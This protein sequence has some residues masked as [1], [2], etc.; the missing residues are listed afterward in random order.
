MADDRGGPKRLPRGRLGRLARLAAIGARAGSSRI[1]G[2]VGSRD[3]A[4]RKVAEAAAEALGNLRGLALKAGQMASYV[5]GTVP[6]EHRDLYEEAMK[7]LR[8]AAPHMGADGA[9]R[10]IERELGAAPEDL[11]A[12]WEPEPFASASIGQVHRATLDDGSAVAVKVQLEG[13]EQA[14]RADLDNAT[15]MTSLLGPLGT[16]FGIGEQMEE[17]RSR[18]LEELDYVHEATRQTR[19]A[20]LFEGDATVRVPAI[21]AERST[22]RVLTAELAT[23]RSFDAARAAPP[24]ERQ[25]WARTLWRFVFHSLFTEGLFNADP[26]PGNYIFDA[27]GVVH[28]LD[29]GC[30]RELPPD[31]TE[32]VR[33][34][35][36]LAI[37]GDHD[38]LADQALDTFG[39]SGVEGLA[40]DLARDY[41]VNCFR[42]IWTRGR[43]RLTSDYAASLL[44]GLRDGA[45]R[46]LREGGEVAPLP[47]Q[48]VFFNRLQLG[49]YSVLA[50]LDVEVDYHALDA[51][52]LDEAGG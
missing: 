18:L 10:V 40:T 6:A 4:E 23:G 1:A 14:V 16:K 42:P 46:V 15:V 52:L 22:R 20:Q 24:E 51:A 11:F 34:L 17:V 41:V 38:G 45:W 31:D 28:F 21:V 48:W 30:T 37:A 36:R 49:F 29:F 50:R 32:K 19:F 25:R 26:H 35:H 13:V 5:D 7:R 3:L 44:S 43:F 12:T 8:D 9:R 33:Q 27:E 39:M 2:L 47:A